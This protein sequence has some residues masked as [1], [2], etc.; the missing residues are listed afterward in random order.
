MIKNN[1][2]TGNK[3]TYFIAI[4]RITFKKLNKCNEC[5]IYQN[6]ALFTSGEDSLRDV[7]TSSAERDIIRRRWCRKTKKN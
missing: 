3:I 1:K 7:D 4:R 6:S 5:V 2:T